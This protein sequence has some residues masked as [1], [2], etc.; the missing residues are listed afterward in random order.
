LNTLKIVKLNQGG[1]ALK[2]ARFFDSANFF[3]AG[4]LILSNLAAGGATIFGFS[5]ATFGSSLKLVKQNALTL[6]VSICTGS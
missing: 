1:G 3:C 4:S 6:V 5:T 2:A